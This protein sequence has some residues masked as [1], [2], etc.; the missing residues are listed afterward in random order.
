MANENIKFGEEVPKDIRVE[1]YQ[2][3]LKA[4]ER[5][6]IVHGLNSPDMDHMPNYQL[7]FLLPCLLYNRDFR[8]L[9]YRK[10]VSWVFTPY[11]FPEIKNWANHI[12]PTLPYGMQREET[13]K[14]RME[15]LLEAINTLI[16]EEY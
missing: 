11:M 1:V 6:I 9:F 13:N 15:V 12:A 10:D 2:K 7:C 14:M 3:A 5:G 16:Y 8:D 4:I